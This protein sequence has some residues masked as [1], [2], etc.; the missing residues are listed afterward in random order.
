MDIL[1]KE[2]GL[3]LNNKIEYTTFARRFSGRFPLVSYLGMQ[4]IFWIVASIFL[5]GILNLHFRAISKTFALPNLNRIGPLI[6]VATILGLLQGIVLGLAEYYINK[7]LLKRQSFGKTVLLRTI[8][9]FSLILLLFV[10]LRFVLFDRFI[11]LR[12]YDT[13][14]TLTKESWKELFG[15]LALFYFVMTIIINLIIQVNQKFG[16]GVLLPLLLGRYSKPQ[17]EERI[18]M[19]M[20]LKSST[21]IAEKLGHFQYSS[22]VRDSIMDINQELSPFNAKVYQYVGDEVILTWKVQDGLKDFSCIRFFFAC[23]RHF[24]SRAVHYKSKYGVIPCFKAGLHM[25]KISAVEI[26]QIKKDIAYYGDTVNTTSRIQGVCNDL[27]K[28]LLVSTDLL[29][30]MG[31]HNNCKVEAMGTILL[32][33]KAQRVGLVSVEWTENS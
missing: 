28:R 27:D 11:A 2:T 17:E 26:G 25:G 29:E 30:K 3:S 21:Q 14:V 19:F 23:E 22:F 16:P 32:K 10:F 20:D 13:I 9:S 15:L 24:Q 5:A 33:G 6:L 31:S 4:M 8:I 18:F 1:L 12:S 7:R